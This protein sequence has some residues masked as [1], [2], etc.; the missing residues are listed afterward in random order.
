MYFIT[1]ITH[2]FSRLGV[3]FKSS[4]PLYK[5]SYTK[6]LK[7]FRINLGECVQRKIDCTT[8]NVT[9]STKEHVIISR[10]VIQRDMSEGIKLEDRQEVFKVSKTSRPVFIGDASLGK[11]YD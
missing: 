2:G 5:I 11:K 4:V 1:S 10:T 3:R 9:V 8:W 6:G 7:S